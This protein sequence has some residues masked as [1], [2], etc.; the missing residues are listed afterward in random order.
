VDRFLGTLGAWQTVN[1]LQEA[2]S[3][4]HACLQ[5]A[6]P[7]ELDTQ[8]LRFVKR[9]GEANL[10]E[11]GCAALACGAM[12]EHGGSPDI[13]G[14]ALIERTSDLLMDMAAFW[15]EVHH[16]SG[17]IPTPQNATALGE[18]NFNEVVAINQRAAW[19]FYGCKVLLLGIVTHLSRSKALRATARSRP[20][21]LQMPRN[22][23][24]A[25]S[26]HSHLGCL[27]RVLDDEP[28]LVLHAGERKGYGVRMT[29][30]ADELQLDTLLAARLIGDPAAGWLPGRPPSPA[31]LS[32]VTNGSVRPDLQVQGAFNLW[33]WGGLRP[34]ATLPAGPGPDTRHLLPWNAFPD[35]IPLFDGV[36][37]VLLGPRN[38]P[39]DWAGT[40]RYRELPGDLIVEGMLPSGEVAAWLER[41]RKADRASAPGS[42]LRASRSNSK[43]SLLH[44]GKWTSMRSCGRLRRL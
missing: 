29:G 23:D 36:R 27:L 32:A 17:T 10:I 20:Q 15:E 2:S 31:I 1:Q 3:G 11:V 25:F 28:L 24:F 44:N 37:V 18:R 39:I 16:R 14:P 42:S 43:A 5:S 7:D 33:I 6:K 35:Q 30:I 13:C 38:P 21:L 12:V 9:L 4:V 41:I 19:A 40:R 34:D 22:A 26:E 8:L